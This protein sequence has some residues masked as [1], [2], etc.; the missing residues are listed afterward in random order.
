MVKPEEIARLKREISKERSQL[1]TARRLA[2]EQREFERLLK[3]K[4]KLRK[5]IKSIKPKGKFQ[6]LVK[7][8]DETLK[9]PKTKKKVNRG[10]KKIDKF[11]DSFGFD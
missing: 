9:N 1:E 8:F 5:E 7:G 2:K 6:T 10:L 3:Q 11:L 4:K